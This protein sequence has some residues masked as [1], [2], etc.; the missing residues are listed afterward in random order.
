VQKEDGQVWYVHGHL[1]VSHSRNK[2]IRI[3]FDAL[4]LEDRRTL[5]PKFPAQFP[6]PMDRAHPGPYWARCPAT[7][8]I[9][10]PCPPG[11]SGFS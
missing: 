5:S 10:M 11:A 4:L 6:I 7:K 9:S 1:P 2:L 3:Y 8:G